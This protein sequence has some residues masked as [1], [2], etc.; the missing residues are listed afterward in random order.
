M[1]RTV[2][3]KHDETRHMLMA[4]ISSY[5]LLKHLK[6]WNAVDD[7]DR[8]SIRCGPCILGVGIALACCLLRLCRLVEGEPERLWTSLLPWPSLEDQ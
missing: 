8:E 2:I 1:A 5:E 6:A 4:T 3:A 7:T